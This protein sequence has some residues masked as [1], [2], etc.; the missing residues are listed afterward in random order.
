M[1]SYDL[2][3]I[4][5]V[6]LREAID[7]P[8]QAAGGHPG[9]PLGGFDVRVPEDPLDLIEIHASIDEASS[10]RVPQGVDYE[11]RILYPEGILGLVPEPRAVEQGEMSEFRVRQN[12]CCSFR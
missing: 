7:G 6:V 2:R 1:D 11:L 5:V 12:G 4:M 9:V 3:H 10:C 8:A